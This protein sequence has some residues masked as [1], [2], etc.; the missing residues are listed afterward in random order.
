MNLYNV[1]FMD[2][3]IKRYHRIS[4]LR[5]NVFSGFI[6]SGGYN[7]IALIAYPIYLKYIGAEKYGLWVTVTV[8]L[9]F[10]Q[11]G[12]LGIETAIIK[13]VAREYGKKN[14]KSI[15]EYIST[16]FYILMVPFVTVIV[17][18]ALFKFQ[19]A[20]LIKLEEVFMDDGVRLI[21]Y[22]GLLSGLNF[23][24]NVIRGVVVGIGRM[25][26]ANYVFLFSRIFRIILAVFLLVLGYGIWSLYFGYLIYLILALVVLIFILGCNYHIKIFDP[27]AFRIKKL[28]ELIKLGGTLSIDFIA[29]MLIVPFNKVII[30]RYIGLSEVTYYQIALQLVMAIRSLWV[31]GLESILPKMSEIYKKT[32]ES[33]KSVLSVHKK[34]MKYILLFGFPLFISIFILANPIL[35]IWLGEEFNIQ[36]AVALKILVI[37]WLI[38]ALTVP[39]YYMFIGIDKA[40]Y[41]VGSTCLTCFI[42]VT[43]ILLIIFL[44]IRFDLMKVVAIN[45][46]SNIVGAI[47][48]KYKY[49]EFRKL[50]N[51]D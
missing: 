30:A 43:L 38:N 15:T 28:R 25:D 51:A 35:R 3:I 18:V 39:E 49:F 1:Q 32:I 6:F 22:V 42:N 10:S 47:F 17:I 8:V 34:A 13:Y 48:L 24:V 26:I 12:Q 31:K 19:I 50:N 20:A 7:V 14:F 46:I 36:I 44:N 16:S 2:K 45:S 40:R 11:F 5:K 29:H 37:G 4:Q 21:F 27:L 23:F 9:E 41:S 33:I